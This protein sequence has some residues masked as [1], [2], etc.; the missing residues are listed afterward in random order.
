[1]FVTKQMNL[2]DD[3]VET[4]PFNF[5]A[6]EEPALAEAVKRKWRERLQSRGIRLVLSPAL[7]G[8]RWKE[9]YEN[10]GLHN[11]TGRR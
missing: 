8:L 10:I 4:N 6:V 1:M 9:S 3:V 11:F 2:K 5:L 7:D